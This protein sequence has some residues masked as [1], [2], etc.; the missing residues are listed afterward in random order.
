MRLYSELLELVWDGLIQLLIIHAIYPV[1]RLGLGDIINRSS[2]VQVGTSSWTQVTTGQAWCM[3]IT[4]VGA[5]YA[6]GQNS[7]GTLGL[8]RTGSYSVSSPVQVGSSS[9]S[10]ISAGYSYGLGITST[11]NLFT[12]G[13]NSVGQ[14]GIE[15]S[16]LLLTNAVLTSRSTPVQIGYINSITSSPV[17]VATGSWTQVTARLNYTAALSTANILYAWGMNNS[18]QVGSGNMSQV[19]VTSPVQISTSAFTAVSVGEQHTLII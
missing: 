4:S 7:N 19:V 9:W 10:Q 15:N 8:G 13:L 12:W 5:L 3:G 2:P 11:G 18:I 1:L 6:W 14:L 17:Q 16:G